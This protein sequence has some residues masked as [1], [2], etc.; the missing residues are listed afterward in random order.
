[1][2]QDEPLR[3]AIGRKFSN[4]GMHYAGLLCDEHLERKAGQRARRDDE[5]VLLVLEDTFERL[6]KFG[7]NFIRQTYIEQASRVVN[8]LFEVF[9]VQ[10]FA[11]VRHR[12]LKPIPA[13]GG[14][15]PG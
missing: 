10:A 15:V 6:K 13:D 11:Q 2:A 1:M 3:V 8:V 5:K 14:L 9:R 7:V 4:R 12:V